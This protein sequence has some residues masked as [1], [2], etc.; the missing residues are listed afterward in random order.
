MKEKKEEEAGTESI[1]RFEKSKRLVERKKKE[2]EKN[3]CLY[4]EDETSFSL[5]VS[6]VGLD[7]TLI[8]IS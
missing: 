4:H 7:T 2:E 5:F 6:L 1:M 8:S 3:A